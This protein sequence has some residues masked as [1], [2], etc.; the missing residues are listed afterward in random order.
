VGRVIPTGGYTYILSTV[1][2]TVYGQLMLKWRVNEADPLPASAGGKLSHIGHLLLDPWVISAFASAGLAAGTWMLAVSQFP[3]SRAY[4]F[5]S[6]AFG[7]VL[8]GA[9]VFFA[10]PLTTPKVIGVLLIG[11][12][13][14]VGAQG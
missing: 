1:L 12:G 13:I 11:V 2:F 5:M 10:E 3:I 7:L 14:I 8:I 6:A 4:P 9:S